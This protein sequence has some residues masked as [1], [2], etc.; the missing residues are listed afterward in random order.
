MRKICNEMKIKDVTEKVYY[1]KFDVYSENDK[2]MWTT[3]YQL[4]NT[5]LDT[6]MEY[7]QDIYYLNKDISY[8]TIYY[9]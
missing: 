8:D 2:L 9:I 3:D 1:Y 7:S 6:N 5:S 4:H